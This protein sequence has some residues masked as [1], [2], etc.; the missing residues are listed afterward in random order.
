MKMVSLQLKLML[1][2]LLIKGLMLGGV[3][4]DYVLVPI[5]YYIALLLVGILALDNELDY[6]LYV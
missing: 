2:S 6:L 3:G 4:S 1:L 5:D